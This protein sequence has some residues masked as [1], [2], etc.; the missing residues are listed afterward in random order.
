MHTAG[1]RRVRVCLA[2]CRRTA[3][4][5][6]HD[7]SRTPA[8]RAHRA[9][10][11]HLRRARCANRARSR[12]IRARIAAALVPQRHVPKL[13]LPDRQRQRTLHDRMAG[14]LPRGKGR[15]LYAAVRGR[16]DVGPRA[17]RARRGHARLD[18]ARDRAR[19]PA[20]L[21]PAWRT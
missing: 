12:R 10:R 1:G 5:F 17:R 15:R 14:A 8:R 19:R 3:A 20:T 16:R 18:A 2:R 9:A 4:R 21:D 13:P 7:R 6:S 11:R